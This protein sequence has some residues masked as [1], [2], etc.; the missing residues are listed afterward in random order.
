MLAVA[1]APVESHQ[2]IPGTDEIEIQSL[3]PFP[4]YVGLSLTPSSNSIIVETA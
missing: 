2:I 4:P 3:A 1:A